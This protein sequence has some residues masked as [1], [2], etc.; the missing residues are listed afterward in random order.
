[1]KTGVIIQARTSSTRLP[2]KVL[3]PLPFNSGF[4]VLQ[5]VIRRAKR[6]KEVDV[7]IVAT[8][9]DIEDL[10][11]VAVAKKE[12]VLFWQGNKEN[13]LERFY[14]AAKVNK[15]DTIIRITSD[16]P[17]LDS[18]IV[19]ALLQEHIARN[20]DYTSNSLLRQYP[21][22]ID[23]EVFNFSVL[24][25]AFNNATLPFEKEHVTPYI[26]KSHP[27]LF[28]IVSHRALDNHKAPELR[29]TLD[30]IQDYTLLCAVYDYLYPKN[31]FFGV[32]DIVKLFDEKP[33]LKLI[34]E[35]V[36]QKKNI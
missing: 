10:Q 35:C 24:E 17:C 2:G 1:M 11:I 13:V 8:T 26:Y 32:E 4:N 33:W 9:K 20:A 25:K 22:G 6:I 15:L 29:I 16:C 27:E 21:H 3:R 30:T 14:E 18:D 7:I 31:I 12:E 36:E 5:Q 34:N 19:S 23:A 28:N